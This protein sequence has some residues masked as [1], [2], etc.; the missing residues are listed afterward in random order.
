MGAV[1]AKHARLVLTN[2]LFYGHLG[3]SASGHAGPIPLTA[4][5][6]LKMLFN[7]ALA[8]YRLVDKGPTYLD[9]LAGARV[10]AFK[11]DLQLER[12]LQTDERLLKRTHIAPVLASRFRAPLGRRWGA[13]LYGDVGGFGIS[14]ALSW[15]LTGTVH[16]ELSE[17]WQLGAGWRH[18]YARDAKRGLQ[19]QEKLDGPIAIFSYRFQQN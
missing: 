14:S 11:V 16:Y 10:T 5:V 8:G 3:I 1:E 18:F 17:H 2:D 9:V 19:V 4:D 12:P 13:H 15:Q 7:T 6:D